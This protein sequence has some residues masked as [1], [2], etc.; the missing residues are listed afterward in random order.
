MSRLAWLDAGGVYAM[1]IRAE[2]VYGQE[3]YKGGFQSTKPN[4]WK[5]FTRA[6]MLIAQNGPARM[7]R[8]SGR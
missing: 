7:A 6:R 5:D 1:R 4:T 8:H 3:W 2:R